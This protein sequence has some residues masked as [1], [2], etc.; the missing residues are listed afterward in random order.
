MRAANFFILGVDKLYYMQYNVDRKREREQKEACDWY[1][2]EDV[3]FDTYA[4]YD[5][6]LGFCI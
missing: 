2:A 5:R 1:E 4:D 3:S 6:R